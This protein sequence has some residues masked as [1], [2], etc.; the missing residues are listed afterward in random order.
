MATPGSAAGPSGSRASAPASTS[1]GLSNAQEEVVAAIQL[2]VR[3]EVQSAVAREVEA[4][5]SRAI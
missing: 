5:V 2:A 1:T 3:R 4:A